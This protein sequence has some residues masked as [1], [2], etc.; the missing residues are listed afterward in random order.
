MKEAQRQS[1][2]IFQIACVK[3][4]TNCIGNESIKVNNVCYYVNFFREKMSITEMN[5][6]CL[7]KNL[8]LIDEPLNDDSAILDLLF[9]K[10]FVLFDMPHKTDI[11]E[12]FYG[13]V[14]FRIDHNLVIP[15]S[16]L[17]YFCIFSII[18]LK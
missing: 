9:F 2:R 13:Y 7:R 18:Y 3:E 10:P 6:F 17:I 12:R 11:K 15:T 4:P 5:N 8:T 14:T 1:N 16:R